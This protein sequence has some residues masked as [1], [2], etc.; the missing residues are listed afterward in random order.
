MRAQ[1]GQIDGQPTFGGPDGDRDR[2]TKAGLAIQKT[3]GPILAGRNLGD[4][5]SGGGAGLAAHG[6]KRATEQGR[7]AAACH[8]QHHVTAQEAAGQLRFQIAQ[9]QAREARIGGAE[10]EYIF[11]PAPGIHQP[12][13]RQLQAFLPDI[14]S[15][16]SGARARCGTA[17]IDPMY[18]HGEEADQ[19]AIRLAAFPHRGGE[20]DVVEV[21]A[22]CGRRIGQHGIAVAQRR[23]T[24]D[25]QR[26]PHPGAQ[27]IGD[28]DR[29]AAARLRHQRALWVNEADCVVFVFLDQRAEG[30]ALDIS[31][32]LVGD[33][34]NFV[35]QH[36]QR[37]RVVMACVWQ[38]IGHAM[39]LL[40]RRP[41]GW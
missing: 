17:D 32:D 36:L 19:R 31:L 13:A 8:I 18:Q 24:M 9:Q 20:H 7:A 28:E 10:P 6:V 41:R 27:C 3:L 23:R 35:P 4:D 33:G 25:L 22:E 11:V 1:A 5:S 29:Q 12:H 26:L 14:G 21:L 16:G 38:G 37:D 30:R 34:E 2:H 15:V 40:N 39:L